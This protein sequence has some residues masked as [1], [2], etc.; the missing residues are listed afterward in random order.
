M[1]TDSGILKSYMGSLLSVAF[2][3]LT[4]AFAYLKAEILVK[5]RDIDI[6]TADEKYYYDEADRFTAENGFNIAVGL[7]NYDG[8]G[9]YI[10][11]PDYGELV[12]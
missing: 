8:K 11:T 2:Y 7:T 5:K 10:L 9:G 12:F 4:I 1:D 3:L 6:L